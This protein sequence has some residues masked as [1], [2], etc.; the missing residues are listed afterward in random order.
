VRIGDVSS[1]LLEGV[2]A[3]TGEAVVF[4]HGN[5]GSLLDWLGSPEE[6]EP[7]CP[8]GGPRHAEIWQDPFISVRYRAPV[9]GVRE[10]EVVVL[11]ESGHWPFAEDPVGVVEALL[12]FLGPKLGV[13]GPRLAVGSSLC[14]FSARSAGE[15]RKI[16]LDWGGDN[17]SPQGIKS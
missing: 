8:R 15:L 14:P 1:P 3:D 7:V 17:G 10:R 13:T 5:P 11:E 4:V 12:P 9:G 16:G 2:L 6:S